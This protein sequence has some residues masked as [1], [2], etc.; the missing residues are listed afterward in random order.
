MRLISVRQSP[1]KY[2]IGKYLVPYQE[3]GPSQKTGF[4]HAI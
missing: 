4:N 1:Q 2:P 3:Y